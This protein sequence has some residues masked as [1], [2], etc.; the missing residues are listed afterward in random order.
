MDWTVLGQDKWQAFVHTVLKLQFR[1][2]W[3][4]LV[5]V[6]NYYLSKKYILSSCQTM[7]KDFILCVTCSDSA[8]KY[9]TNVKATFIS[10]IIQA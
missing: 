7:P 2:N 8:Y 1:N 9:P 10:I 6:H 5:W 4:F 3:E